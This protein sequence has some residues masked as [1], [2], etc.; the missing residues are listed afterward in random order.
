MES[1]ENYQDEAYAYIKKMIITLTLRPGQH[2]TISSLKEQLGIGTTPI[3]EAIIRLRREGL[4]R[5]I[6]QSGTYVSKINMDEVYQARFVREDLETLIFSD[7]AAKMSLQQLAELEQNTELQK[8]YLKAKNYDRFFELDE[9]FHKY[10]YEVTGKTYVWNWLQLLNAQFN[11]FRYLRLEVSGLNWDEIL[12][13]HEGIVEALRRRDQATVVQL[14]G[15][16]LHLVDNDVKTVMIAASEY[17]ET[18]SKA[19]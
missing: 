17:F 15:Q 5:V 10:F 3:R 1:P 12:R 6:P 9:Q 16:H 13:Q 14:V 4:F 2:V 7:A 19:E 8:I 11:R 18:V